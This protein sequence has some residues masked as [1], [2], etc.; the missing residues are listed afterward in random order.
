MSN[1]STYNGCFQKPNR[2]PQHMLKPRQVLIGII[3]LL[4]IS[5]SPLVN[6]NVL[7]GESSIESSSELNSINGLSNSESHW[8]LISGESQTGHST[9]ELSG[10]L[11]LAHGSFDPLA[12]EFPTIPLSYVDYNDYD[13]TGMKYIQFHDYDYQLITELEEAGHLTVLDILGEGNFIVRILPTHTNTLDILTNSELIRYVGNV[14]PGYRLHPSLLYDNVYSTVSIIPAS[15]L[16]YGGY[17]ELALDLLR[18]G[19]N[20]A[21]CGFTMCQVEMRDSEEFLFNA[22]RDG[23]IL[24]IEPTSSMEVHNGVARAISGVVSLDADASFTL[25]GSGE[26]LAIADT[27]LDRDHPDIAGRVA[28]IYT[29]FGLDTSPADSNGGHGTHVTLTAI[30]DGSSDSSTKGIAPAASVTMYALEYDPTGTFGRQGS[31]YDLLAD[32]KQK[33][34][35]IAINA[36][37]LS[38]SEGEYTADSR[39]VDQFVKDERSLLPIFSVGDWD[40][41]GSSMV[42]TPATA[43]NVLS[44][45]VSTTGTGGTTP[46]GAVDAISRDGST[47]DGRIKPDVVA[48]GIEICSGRAEEARNPSGFACGSGTHGNGDPL[49]MSLSGTSQS[50]SVAGGLAALTREYLREQ[51]GIS[52]PSA[53][54]I[55]AAMINGAED[56][57]ALDVPNNQEGWGQLNIENTVMPMD[58]ATQLATYYDD[59]KTLQ[60][61]FGLLYELNLDI[62]HGLEITLAWN[63]EAGSATS[64][65]SDAKL[66][67]DL[68]LIVFDPD[69]NQY[70]G[71][72]FNGGY[73]VIGVVSDTKNNVER[74][75]IP[76]GSLTNS[77]QWLVQ[78]IHRG[79]VDQDFSI[80]M[81]GDASIVARPDIYAFSD[82]IFLSSESPLQND[83][84]SVRVSWMNQ[85]TAD[86]GSFDWKL[87]DL[88][89]GTILFQGQSN[90]VASSGIESKITTHSFSTTG[91]HTLKLTL[92]TNNVLN[93]MNDESS[94][95]NNNV[96]EIEIEVTA[97][98][99]RVIPLDGEGNIPTSEED[100]QQAAINIFDVRNETEINIP[101]SIRNEGTG[102]EMVTLSYTNVQ[103]KHPVFN[104][105]I[106]PEDNWQ[107]GVSQ[108]GPYQLSPQGQSGD[109][110]QVSL[111]FDNLNANLDDPNNPRYARSG[112][113]YVDVTVAYQTQPTV[114]HSIRLTIIIDEVD[115]VKIVVSGTNGLSALPGESASFA[116]SA[117]NTGNS[118][119]QYSVECFSENLWQIMLGNSNSSSL[120]FEPLDIGTYL[121][122]PVRIFVPEISQGSPASGF[123]DTI[124]C[125]VTSSTDLTLNYSQSVTVEV[126]ELSLYTTN[127]INNGMDVGTNLQ[128]RDVMID[129]GE[130][131]TLDY[132]VIN[133]GNVD[134]S[135]DVIVQPSNP[136]WYVDLVYDGLF[137]SN[138]VPVIVPA[139]QT[140]SIQIIIASP[141]SSLEGDFNLFNIKAEVSN[142]DYV[143]NNTRLVIIDKLSIDLE[144]PEIIDCVLSDDYSYADFIISND[145]NSVADLEWSY[146]LPPDGWIV[147]FANPVTQLD[148]REN[149]TVKLGIIPPIN[150]DVTDSAF[151]ISISVTAT[152]GDRQIDETVILDVKVSESTFG[153]ITLND[154]VLQPLQ[155]VPKGSSQSTTIEVRN[156]GNVVLQGEL[157]VKIV[158]DAGNLIDGWRPAVTPETVEISPGQVQSVTVEVSPKDSVERG[159]YTLIV[160]LESDGE[161]LTSFNLQT[162]SSP[163]EGNKGLFNIVP[164]YV[165]VLVLGALAAV[166]LV[167]SRKMRNSGSTEDDGTQLVRADAYGNLPDVSSRRDKALDI[168]LSQDDMTSGSVSQEEIAAALAKSMADQFTPPPS[169]NPIPVGLPPLGMPPAGMPP[170]GMPP[171]GL[172]PLGQVPNGMPP[173]VPQKSVPKLPQPAPQP[174]PQTVPSTTIPA[175][176]PP[177]PATG[178]PPGW[179]MEQWNAYGQ[180]WLDKNQR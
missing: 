168:G 174:A 83:V 162:S 8:N 133:L 3:L 158:D 44:V 35:R 41:T 9:R 62:A 111:I 117:L 118:E 125:Y 66:I 46:Q 177:L 109:D 4:G 85:G 1:F 25:D 92:D 49:Y 110:I 151:K 30:G 124:Q 122:M 166:I 131:V 127:L 101:I 61:S 114:S 16:G 68:D 132:Q 48:P 53:S 10:L 75:S 88:T 119:A 156:D 63:D 17:E 136:S 123:E 67:N 23:R 165:S 15:D 108:T 107:K 129:S 81:T 19:A 2:F 126:D 29:Q 71:N 178:L 60:P 97:L 160:T 134:I 40:G 69:G 171:A 104:Y 54:L 39:S 137:Y 89:M 42:T 94:G 115:D 180:M 175:T 82:S 145:G 149:Q 153:N 102:T 99:V 90:G 105:F 32:A 43:K 65:Q 128:V 93:E 59:G 84:V 116:I 27:G 73:S 179:S 45:G 167:L 74:V 79:G 154:E 120:D 146:S 87:E 11:N 5:F 155:S 72:N 141:V 143:S 77:G 150:Q 113:F 58:G 98:G 169:V 164:W 142:F 86:A 28:A 51:V 91:L 12:D 34:A 140:E 96:L 47:M 121:S 148:P 50:A 37:G 14:Q 157:S 26:M 18:F 22:A 24:W 172:P 106:S 13:V 161:E 130:E 36:W 56:L 20:D 64:S 135:L 170:A 112:T 95:I 6:S 31:I 100:R 38:G 176:P 163:A 103:E 33:T 144:S 57:G 76:S 70:Y 138:E 80:V 152:N 147:G 21:W 55:K 78:V 52:S 173:I 159:P 7:V 139:G